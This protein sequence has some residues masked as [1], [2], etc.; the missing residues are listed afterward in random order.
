MDKDLEKE[1]RAIVKLMLDKASIDEPYRQLCLTDPAA[2]FKQMTGKSLCKGAGLRFAEGKTIPLS[3]KRKG[4]SNKD[5]EMASRK[6]VLKI[7]KG[8]ISS[9][10]WYGIA[11][12]PPWG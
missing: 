9:V 11:G 2:A 8:K 7:P 10:P 3:P 12:T 6:L 1:G 4:L 5:L